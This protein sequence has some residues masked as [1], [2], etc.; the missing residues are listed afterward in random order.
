MTRYQFDVDRDSLKAFADPILVGSI[1]LLVGLGLVTLYSASFAFSDRFFHDGLYF[2]K[3]QVAYAA[4]GLLLFAIASRVKLDLIRR[5]IGPLVLGVL[6]LCLLTFLPGIGVS[7]NGASRWIRIGSSTYQP[8]ELV[9]VVLPIYL[10]HIFDKKKDRMDNFFTSVLPPTLVTVLFF[11]IIYL[12]NNFSTASFIMVNALVI[13]F[14][15]GLKLRYFF[16]AALLTAPLSLLLV[17]TKE[18]RLRRLMTFIS[19]EWDPLGAGYQVRSSILT[20]VS[21]GWWGKGIGQGTRKIASVPEIHSDFI[22]SAFA[23]EAGLMGVVLFF[24]LFSVFVVRS[25]RAALRSDLI[26]Q[27]LLAC[28]MGTIIASQGLLNVAVVAGALPATGVPLPFFSAGGSSLATM[29]FS[30][31][32]IVNI[33]RQS[34]KP[35]VFHV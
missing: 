31:G 33:S 21:G 8:S 29:L 6:F 25:F 3:R 28:A 18:H 17:L 19:P 15:A 23:E 26:F 32:L 35:E 20:I 30:A 10:A 24:A 16:A 22:F 4:L 34:Q 5:F 2:L 14:L 27:R 7:K 11:L 13:F 12:Q 1:L 9:K